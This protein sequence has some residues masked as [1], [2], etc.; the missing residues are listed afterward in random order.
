MKEGDAYSR[1]RVGRNL[2]R[3]QHEASAAVGDAHEA[4]FRGAGDSC[5][6]HTGGGTN[7]EDGMKEFIKGRQRSAVY[8]GG[9]E[10]SRVGQGGLRE[11]AVRSAINWTTAV[12]FVR[13]FGRVFLE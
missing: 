1:G 7:A 6:R 10:F 9:K 4:A 2:E 5:A 11:Q 8:F 12:I 13:R 3:E